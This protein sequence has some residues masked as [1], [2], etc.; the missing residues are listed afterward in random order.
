VAERG[1]PGETYAIGGLCERT[2]ID[3]VRIVCALLDEMA[4]DSRLGSRENLIEF[5]TDRPGHDH[6][7]AIDASKIRT[8]LGWEPQES[9]ESGMAGTVRWYLDNRPWWERIRSGV[10]RGQR[11]GLAS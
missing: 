6:R 1:I 2:N 3:V 5:V 9:F 8:E 10:Y 7:Y 11:L 4:P